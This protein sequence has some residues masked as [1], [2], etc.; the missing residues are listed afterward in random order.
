MYFLEEKI[1][2]GQLKKTTKK[3]PHILPKLYFQIDYLS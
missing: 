2:E 1:Y 3:P